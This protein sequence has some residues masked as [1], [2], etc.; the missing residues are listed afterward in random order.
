MSL[1]AGRINTQLRGERRE[2]A[3]L[4]VSVRSPV[5]ARAAVAGGRRSSTSKSPR[6]GRWGVLT[7]LSGKLCDRRFRDRLHVSVALGELNEWIGSERLHIS[8]WRLGRYRV[9]QAW[10][11]GGARLAG[12]DCWR[13]LRD[14]LRAH[15][16]PFP[17]WV[18]VVYL[19]WEAARAPHPEAIIDAAIEM[20]EC[21]AVLFDTWSKSSGMRLDRSWKLRVQ[22]VR[23]SGTAGRACRLAGRG[24][25]RTVDGLAARRLCGSGARP[26]PGVIASG[27]SMPGGSAR[28]AEA[29]RSGSEVGESSA[30][31]ARSNVEPHAL[32]QRQLPAVIDRT[33]L[34][35]HVGFPGVGSGFPATAGGFFAT[36]GTADFGT[37]GADVHVGDAAV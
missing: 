4:L 34:P 36:E 2:L 8:R 16:S 24:G 29:V 11:R 9:L 7:R 22:K 33:S 25:D 30:Q 6:G 31:R 14:D 23:D 13:R 15:A 26:V 28:L 10:P 5:E 17:D 27:G 20:P 19:D 35:A 21:R 37:G 18:A 1:G 3:S 12:S 32:S